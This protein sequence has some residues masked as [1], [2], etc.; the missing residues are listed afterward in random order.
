[1]KHAVFAGTMVYLPLPAGWRDRLARGAGGST[2]R[3]SSRRDTGATLREVGKH[4]STPRLRGR[5][6]RVSKQ[7]VEW[8]SHGA[9]KRRQTVRVEPALRPPQVDSRR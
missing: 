3:R 5:A 8:F 7:T 9:A 2:D 1:M 4:K 6:E